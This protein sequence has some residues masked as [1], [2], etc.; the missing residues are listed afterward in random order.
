MGVRPATTAFGCFSLLGGVTIVCAITLFESVLTLGEVNSFE[1]Q[2]DVWEGTLS[3]IGIVVAIIG[4]VAVLYRI[5]YALRVY[6]WFLCFSFVFYLF[7]NFRWVLLLSP[8]YVYCI[9]IVWSACEEVSMC[10]FPELCNN[11]AAL[12]YA[13]S[14]DMQNQDQK[15]P[16][17]Q[18]PNG[19]T[20][21]I[22]PVCPPTRQMWMNNPSWRQGMPQ[23]FM[24]MSNSGF[25]P[26]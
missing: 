2:K 24:P 20:V 8:I 6:L 26:M 14:P 16:E 7:I 10:E 15:E 5:E 4:G 9:Y 23:S 22:V 11:S 17:K 25:L 3:L 19:P 21:P 12:K 1:S 18:I 13:Y